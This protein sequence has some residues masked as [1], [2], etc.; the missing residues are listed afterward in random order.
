MWEEARRAQDYMGEA[1]A[2]IT[3]T[4][5]DVRM[6]CHDALS[7]GHDKH[8]RCFAAFPPQAVRDAAVRVIRTDPRGRVKMEIVVGEDYLPG[9]G[10]DLW[11]LL[12]KGHMQVLLPPSGGPEA[13]SADFNAGHA[14]AEV[15]AVGWARYL[16]K[17]AEEG[18]KVPGDVVR[19]CPRCSAVA[20]EELDCKTGDE[21]SGGVGPRGRALTDGSNPAWRRY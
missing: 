11:L 9:R 14:P 17:A 15:P 16:G 7:A 2:Y 1:D 3:R 4:E 6:F 12:T 21:Q 5:S 8:Y 20:V 10:L 13:P 19:Q 18:P